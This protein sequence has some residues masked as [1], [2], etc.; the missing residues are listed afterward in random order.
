MVIYQI[1]TRYIPGIY[2][3]Y[4]CHACDRDNVDSFSKLSSCRISWSAFCH[5]LGRLQ[6]TGHPSP[7]SKRRWRQPLVLYEGWYVQG[8]A[9]PGHQPPIPPS[10][11]KKSFQREGHQRDSEGSE[12]E[13]R[14]D[15]DSNNISVIVLYC[16]WFSSHI[17]ITVSVISLSYLCH[18]PVIFLSYLCHISVILL[19]Y[20]CHIS[21]ISLSYSFWV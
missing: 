10:L 2:L 20:F 9:T 16:S 21:V 3:V 4:I 5:T 1:Y 11:L 14:A 8:S 18:T 17:L 13:S 19:S 12:S 7:R 15:H 6:P